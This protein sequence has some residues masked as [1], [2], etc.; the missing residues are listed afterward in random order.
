MYRNHDQLWQAERNL[1]ELA[2]PSCKLQSKKKLAKAAVRFGDNSSE[3]EMLNAKTVIC[4]DK[5]AFPS[6]RTFTQI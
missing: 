1:I 3:D 5:R 6:P 2:L 4:K